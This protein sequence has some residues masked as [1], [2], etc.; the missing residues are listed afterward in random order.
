MV[1]F[2]GENKALSVLFWLDEHHVYDILL[3][4]LLACYFIEREIVL[5]SIV[6]L[7]FLN[8]DEMVNQIE[9]SLVPLA[10]V[11]CCGQRVFR[12]RIHRESLP[13]YMWIIDPLYS[14]SCGIYNLRHG[15]VCLNIVYVFGS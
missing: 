13:H 14:A 5:S 12:S 6:V 1:I 3:K 10:L 15:L 2:S 4:C 8:L 9:H 7:V 11:G